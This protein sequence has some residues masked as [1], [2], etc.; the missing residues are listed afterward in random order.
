MFA[1][2]DAC[3]TAAKIRGK[4]AS[5]SVCC[6]SQPLLGAGTRIALQEEDPIMARKAR[7]EAATRWREKEMRDEVGARGK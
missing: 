1:G 4:H 3:S 7:D 2:L 5:E 6:P